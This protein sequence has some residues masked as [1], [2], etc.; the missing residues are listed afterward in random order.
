MA[1]ITIFNVDSSENLQVNTDGRVLNHQQRFF[2]SPILV[3]TKT[4]LNQIQTTT[5]DGYG[6]T[7]LLTP[8]LLVN[9]ASTQRFA[10]TYTDTVYIH[11]VPPVMPSYT[12]PNKDYQ[13]SSTVTVKRRGSY[14]SDNASGTGT[15][16]GTTPYWS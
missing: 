7:N 6:R 12:V 4:P 11:S 3:K 9:S 10:H 13:N 16:T 15:G 14:V 1:I 8:P 2:F 5:I